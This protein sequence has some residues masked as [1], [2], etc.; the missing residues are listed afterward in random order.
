MGYNY[1]YLLPFLNLVSSRRKIRS[2]FLVDKISVIHPSINFYFP[3]DVA[4]RGEPR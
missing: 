2:D 3:V 1:I 4:V